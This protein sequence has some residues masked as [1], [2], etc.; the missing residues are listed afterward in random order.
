VSEKFGT[1]ERDLEQLPDL[2]HLRVESADRRICTIN[3]LVR[4]FPDGILQLLSKR[5]CL[6]RR[7]TENLFGLEG[8]RR[9]RRGGRGIECMQVYRG[10][11]S[12]RPNCRRGA[13]G[14]TIHGHSAN[15][16]R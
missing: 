13:D 8:D 2:G 15:L 10:V 11:P 1:S 9:G 14:R 16:P 4:E 6:S 7:K 5:K 12:D 3:R